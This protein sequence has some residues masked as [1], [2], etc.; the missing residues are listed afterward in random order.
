MLNRFIPYLLRYKRI[1]ILDLFCAALTTICDMVLPLIMSYLTTAATDTAV[2]LTIEIILKLALIYLILRMIDAAAN[3]YMAYN[4]HVMG[5][6]IET[7]M[8]RDAFEHL[9]RL[10]YT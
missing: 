9:Q 7:D 6:Y 3:Y 10:G 1:L 4:G 2:V 5:V 8:R